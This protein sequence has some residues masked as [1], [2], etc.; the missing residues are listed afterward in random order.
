MFIDMPGETD[1]IQQQIKLTDDMPIRCKP[2][3]LPYAIREELKNKVD[4]MLQ[5]GVGRQRRT[6]RPS[7]W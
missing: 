2:H 5:M 4:S 3:P 1:V 7:S 6:C